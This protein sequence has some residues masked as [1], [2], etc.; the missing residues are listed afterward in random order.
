[1]YD[2]STGIQ[3][4]SQALLLSGVKQKLRQTHQSDTL[5]LPAYVV[6]VEFNRSVIHLTKKCAS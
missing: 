4:G 3:V 2:L 1:M 5:C 6:V